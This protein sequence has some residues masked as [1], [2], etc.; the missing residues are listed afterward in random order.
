MKAYRLTQGGEIDG[1]NLVEAPEPRPAQGEVAIRIRATSLNYR[2]LGIARRSAKPVIPLSDG[3]GE[4]SAI[5]EGAR[6][7]VGD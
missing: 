3:A 4:V 6:L 5:G 7:A 2:D 1:L